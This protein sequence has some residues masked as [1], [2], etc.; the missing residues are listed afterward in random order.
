MS[1]SNLSAKSLKRAATIKAKIEQLESE[2]DSILGGSSSAAPKTKVKK[3]PL[4]RGRKKMSAAGRK[5]IAEAQKRRWKAQ[6]ASKA[7]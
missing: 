2:L 6:K 3:A 7:S 5:R 4:K 1:I